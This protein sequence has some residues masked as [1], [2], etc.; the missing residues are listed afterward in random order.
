MSQSLPL[1]P[2]MLDVAGLQLT[3]EERIRLQHPQV[4]GVI[5]FRRNFESREQVA[6]LIAEIKAVRDPALLVAVDHEGGRVQR[7]LEGFTRLPPMQVLGELAERDP[8]AAITMAEQVGEVLA[9]ELR[10][11]GVD[12]S[13]TPVLDLDWG[14]SAIIGNRAFHANPDR[15]TTLAAALIRGLEAGGMSA[16]GKH[17]PGH[18]WVEADS[19][20]AIP[21]DERDYAT[22]EAADLKPFQALAQAGLHS[23][24][25]A[26]VV[27]PQIDSAPAG[28]STFWLQTVLRDRLGFEGVIFS[29]DLC[30]EGAAGVGGIFERA[31]AAFNAGCDMALVCNRPDLAETLLTALQST[32]IATTLAA[33]LARMMGKAS[34]ESWIAHMNTAAFVAKQQQVAALTVPAGHL[35]GPAVGEAC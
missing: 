2:V 31:H 10:A 29:D 27:Y 17:F 7:F 12:L 33:R 5:L 22:I 24:M 28:F 16:C 15:V 19:H 20:H 30:M 21:V 9:V 18:G 35:A 1:G 11:I 6:A 3:D 8:Q 23:V 34:P 32:P 13:F 4:G 25:P 14:H 26:H